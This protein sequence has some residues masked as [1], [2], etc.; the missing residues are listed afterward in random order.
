MLM[1]SVVGESSWSNPISIDQEVIG[2]IETDPK[3]SRTVFQGSGDNRGKSNVSLFTCPSDY[4]TRDLHRNGQGEANTNNPTPVNG[5]VSISLGDMS[6]TQRSNKLPNVPSEYAS[7]QERI[8][9]ILECAGMVGFSK[10]DTVIS[11]YYTAEFSASSN[12]FNAQRISR[13]RHLPEVLASV[14]ES[15][16]SWSPWEVQGY[17]D[18]TLKSSENLLI[19]EYKNAKAS[20]CLPFIDQQVLQEMKRGLLGHEQRHSEDLVIY[21]KGALQ[22]KVLNHAIMDHLLKI[23]Y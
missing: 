14:H 3:I 15:A 20:N 1:V 17:R 18:E 23:I 8:E 5:K 9:F 21:V 16:N 6:G 11:H 22:A 4:P 19:E 7:L 12:A 13:K 10:F 2:G